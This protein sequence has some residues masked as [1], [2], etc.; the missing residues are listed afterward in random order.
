MKVAYIG[1]V[2]ITDSE[3]PLIR[4]FYKKGLD[5][6]CYYPIR[7][8]VFRSGLIDIGDVK[9][10]DDIISSKE[11][12]AFKKYDD[13]YEYSVSNDDRHTDEGKQ[14]EAE[15]KANREK[16][17]SKDL[18]EKSTKEIKKDVEQHIKD[19]NERTKEAKDERASKSAE[20]KAQLK[21]DLSEIRT[22]SDEELNKRINRLQKEKQYSELL[23]ER[24]NR[25]KGPVYEA[26]SKQFKELG[27]KLAQKAIER[28]T[29]ELIKKAF[30]RW[31]ENKPKDN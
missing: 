22:L 15:I 8:H 12:D 29:D 5:I 13:R 28:G 2:A 25:E 7:G 14:K 21:K 11:Y 17:F 6:I 27:M 16:R 1:M 9:K 24:A 23:N 3:F 31:N 18:D 20:E 10:K 4:E 26:V 30:S 19:F